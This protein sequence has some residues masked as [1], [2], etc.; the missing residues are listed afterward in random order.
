M[1][2]A[3]KQCSCTSGEA[4][5]P[6]VGSI[7]II[8]GPMFSGKSSRLLQK[9]QSHAF[10][11]CHCVL[12]KYGTGDR[13]VHDEGTFET[14]S[15]IVQT[16]GGVPSGGRPQ[17]QGN[18]RVASAKKLSD[19]VIDAKETVIGIDEGQFYP[20]LV[21]QCDRLAARGLIVIVAALDGTSDRKPFGQ[22]CE[23]IPKA[24]YMQKMQAVCMHCHTVASASFT[25]KILPNASGDTVIDVGST[26]KYIAVCRRCYNELQVEKAK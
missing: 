17:W 24:E 19:V 8:V 1:A 7:E 26:D 3:N 12:I 14:H 20:D 6:A 2:L 16:S 10:A 15:D 23:L 21:E 4:V 9:M 25:W 13:Y 18:I 22:V 11:K 5:N